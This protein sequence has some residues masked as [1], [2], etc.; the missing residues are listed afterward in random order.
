MKQMR[1]GILTRE[2]SRG[3]LFRTIDQ[4]AQRSGCGLGVR[5]QK[6]AGAVCLFLFVQ[7]DRAGMKT[8]SGNWAKRRVYMDLDVLH[9]PHKFETR[10]GKRCR[11]GG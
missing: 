4:G 3:R 2:G 1:I 8:F 11:K 7:K 10:A 6:A 9:Y 5:R